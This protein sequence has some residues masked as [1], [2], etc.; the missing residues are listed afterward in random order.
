MKVQAI[1]GFVGDTGQ[2]KRGEEIEVTS[3]YGHTLI[4]KG[5]AK[6]VRAKEEPK[7]NK[8]AAPKENK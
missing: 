1:W 8:Q 6:E 7:T 5:L 3:E 4:G 2:V